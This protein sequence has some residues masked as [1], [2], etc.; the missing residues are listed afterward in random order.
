M[1]LWILGF[2]TLTSYPDHGTLTTTDHEYPLMHYTKLISEEHFI[3]GRPLVIVLPLADECTTNEEM[4]YLIEELQSLVRCSI[5]V[6]NMG[7]KIKGNIHTEIN[8]DSSY[9]IL[10]SGP[11]VE[12]KPYIRSF[13]EEMYAFI[14]HNN[15][16][17]SLNQRAKFV[18]TV[19]RNCTQFENINISRAILE[20]LWKFKVMKA[21]AFFLNSNKHAGNDQQQNTTDSAHGTYLE[22][23]TWY[24]YEN[25]DIRN[26]AEGTVPVKVFTVRNLSD[27]C[28]RD[29]FRGHTDKN[30]NGCPITVV[31]IENPLLWYSTDEKETIDFS[32]T[33]SCI[34]NCSWKCT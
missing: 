32:R 13:I 7:N 8:K 3:A 31:V 21:A 9:I 25:S 18:V 5:L 15:R 19:M 34:V 22:L 10:K 11:C 4:G 28:R 12:W 30:F 27:I 1:I 2:V 6:I 16:Q 14:F 23:H 33:G 29:I 26:L 20:Y 17:H 24:P